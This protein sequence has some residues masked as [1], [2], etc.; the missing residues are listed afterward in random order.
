MGRRESRNYYEILEI[1]PVSSMDD[2]KRAYRRAARHFH[3]DLNPGI[4]AQQ[5][6]R[7]VQEAYAVL[8]DPVER[9]SYDRGLGYRTDW[10]AASA[11]EA[12]QR[13]TQKEHEAHRGP[14]E[15]GGRGSDDDPP[16]REE[17]RPPPREEPRP[18][19]REE[20]RPP[21]RDENQASSSRDDTRSSPRS[22]RSTPPPRAEKPA[23]PPRAEKV[24]PA[25]AGLDD[26]MA[27]RRRFTVGG[28]SGGR[29]S[30]RG[31]SA[32]SS[33]WYLDTSLR[34]GLAGG[35]SLLG[36]VLL[37]FVPEVALYVAGCSVGAALLLGQ[38]AL[39]H[40]LD[41]R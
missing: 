37:W 19:P 25:G 38:L 24:P 31:F 23:E 15:S 41:Q 34:L 5:Q 39:L 17:P 27:G 16:I 36:F 28:R 10:V 35:G 40:K 18:P 13:R 12:R 7:L 8:R 21:P 3:P 32:L 22:S 2:V 9:T 1:S 20:P 11:D 6:F 14:A 30:A 26:M 29:T 33:A 4:E